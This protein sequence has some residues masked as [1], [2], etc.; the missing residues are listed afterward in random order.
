MGFFEN[1]IEYSRKKDEEVLSEA[2]INIAGAIVG[3]KIQQS[4]QDESFAAQTALED[5]C[6]Y[7]RIKQVEIPK[8]IKEL[9][10]Q[11]DYV[12]QPR[13]IMRRSVK[14][15]EHWYKDAIGAMLGTFRDSG[16]PVA[17]VPAKMGGYTYRD[18]A[19]G[20]TVKVN[21]KTAANID[22]E[23][24]VFYRPFP[25]R[26]LT[27]KDLVMFLQS[28]LDFVDVFWYLAAMGA[29]TLLGLLM[30]K[31]TNVL[32]GQVVSF[33][34]HSLLL[35]VVVFMVCQTVAVQMIKGIQAL[36]L[37]KIGMKLDL[38]VQAASLMRLFSMPTDLFRK[39]TS[40]ELNQHINYMNQLCSSIVAAVF[41]TGLTGVFS[42]VYITQIFRYSPSLVMPSLIITLLTLVFSVLSVLIGIKISRQTM[43]LGAEERGLVYS[44]IT[45]IQKIRLCGAEKRIF[46]RWGNLYSKEARLLY[47][48]PLIL[49]LGSVITLAISAVGNVVLYFCAQKSGVT[50]PDFYSFSTAFAYITAAFTSLSGVAQTFA[51]VK[52]ILQIVKPLMDAVPEVA[53]EKEV[54]TRLSGAIELSHICFKYPDTDVKVFEDLSLKINPGQ[55]VAIV[56]E[57]GC[58]K[59]T[60]L[61]L[62][63]GFEKPQKG[64][65]YFDG[66]NLEGLD[67]KSLRR[68]IGVVMQGGRLMWGDIFSNITVSAPWLTMD[69]AWEAAEIA[70]IAD[71]IRA[72]PM[73]MNTIVQNGSGGI[74]GGQKQRIMI[75]RAVAP[76]PKI[77]FLDEATSALD[78]ITQKKVSEAM[79]KMRCTRIVIAHRLSTIRQC[80]RILFL[81]GGKVCEDGTYEEL[82]EKDGY[83]ADLVRR[84]MITPKTPANPV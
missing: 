2:Y 33:E 11:L 52:P 70:G 20:E 14:L 67:K 24:I 79:D 16:K 63:L 56:G 13:G 3:H 61:R 43:E 59:T 23:A 48:P 8:T 78:N 5:I 35:G 60:L 58:G 38:S 53:E 22:T 7:Y 37:A 42:L 55:Y 10:A 82:I 77:L 27:V 32:F 12:F 51:A 30:P 28:C 17:L 75:A 65:V 66:K 39:Y 15:A 45:G 29:A 31:L 80:D 34:S 76:K 36:L 73:G 1:Q 74:S 26:A 81:K 4:W 46:A 71:D 83:F 44:I 68:K 57:S 19:S 47:S 54:V 6:K 69:D 64:S 40:G 84:Q 50:V 21:R 49:E 41:S 9:P 62:L 25:L 72:M 18:P